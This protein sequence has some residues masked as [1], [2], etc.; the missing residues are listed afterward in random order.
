MTWLPG[1]SARQV[2]G[3]Q[4]N[5]DGH[6]F[7]PLKEAPF[8]RRDHRENS[9][10]LRKHGIDLKFLIKSQSA[11]DALGSMRVCMK[12]SVNDPT[13]PANPQWAC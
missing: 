9:K 4:I 13:R 8:H 7:M 6:G 2:D 11:G 12:K 10:I 3:S 1:D 5:T